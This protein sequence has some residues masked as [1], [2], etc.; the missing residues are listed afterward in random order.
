MSIQHLQCFVMTLQHLECT[1]WFETPSFPK[2]E[3]TNGHRGQLWP[4]GLSGGEGG[5]VNARLPVWL[6][7]P[8]GGPM[9][10]GG[11]ENEEHF[12]SS[13]NCC[14]SG[15][16]RGF[17]RV[18]D[19]GPLPINPAVWVTQN[20]VIISQEGFTGWANREKHKDVGSCDWAKTTTLSKYGLRRM[21]GRQTVN[22]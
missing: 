4:A 2:V 12:S 14:W 16:M 1:S 21:Q 6:L 7:G 11:K 17:Q 20:M 10:G 18:S 13:N 3:I 15:H 5:G 22:N 8:S 19:I 9:G